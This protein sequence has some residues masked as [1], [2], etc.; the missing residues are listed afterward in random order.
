MGKTFWLNL[1][2]C[3]KSNFHDI[4]L[5]LMLKVYG[6]LNDLDVH[7]TYADLTAQ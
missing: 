1:Q 4:M 6:H 3:E 7:A 2:S 5:H